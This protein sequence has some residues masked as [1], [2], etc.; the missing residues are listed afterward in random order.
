MS[1]FKNSL[2]SALAAGKN[3]ALL[4]QLVLVD[5]KQRQVIYEVGDDIEF[6]Y[7]PEDTV[8][9]LLATM[10]DGASIE[11]GMIG[12]EGIV[13]AS[14]LL[15]DAPSG[16]HVVI[17]LSGKAY[18]LKASLCKAA[19][20]EDPKF[21]AYILRFVDAFLNHSGQTSACNRLHSVEQRSARWLL[22]SSDRKQSDTLPLTQEYLAAMIGVRRSGVTEAAGELQR[23]GLITYNH[24]H[25]KIIDS[26]GLQKSACECYVQDRDRFR[27]LLAIGE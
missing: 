16:Q 11:V 9:S 8:A 7:F 12:F 3:D 26:K 20:D 10:S 13:G 1:K 6:V 27:K 24:G 4:S 21:R 19:F 2:L 15:G 18:R 14:A 25:I 5:L 17:Q 22:M 23:S